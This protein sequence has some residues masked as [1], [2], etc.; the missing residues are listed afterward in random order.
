MKLI[1][2]KR[3]IIFEASAVEKHMDLQFSKEVR[4]D[5]IKRILV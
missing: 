1:N 3:A 2:A 4:G 5:I